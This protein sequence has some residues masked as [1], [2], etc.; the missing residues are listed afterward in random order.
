MISDSNVCGSPGAIN[1]GNL[2]RDSNSSTTDDA[3]TPS[4]SAVGDKII[5]SC[6]DGYILIGPEERFC[7][8]NGSWTGDVPVC[9]ALKGTSHENLEF[10]NCRSALVQ[11]IFFAT[12][13][14]M[15]GTL[16]TSRDT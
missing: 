7:T 15:F 14:R 12:S 10:K 16:G 9:L 2:E 8:Y 6:N 13:C 4:V 11:N 3:G 1:N 5:Y